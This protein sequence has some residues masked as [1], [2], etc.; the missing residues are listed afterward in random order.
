V[1]LE[2]EIASILQRVL[3]PAVIYESVNITADA[4]KAPAGNLS[5][6]EIASTVT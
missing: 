4:A 5:S 2:R 3:W 1:I 6:F